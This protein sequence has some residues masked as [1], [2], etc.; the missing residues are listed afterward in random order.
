MMPM[1]FFFNE[2]KSLTLSAVKIF[3]VV[4]GRRRPVLTF[5]L[6]T[7]YGLSIILGQFNIMSI[8]RLG[9]NAVFLSFIDYEILTWGVRV[10]GSTC[11]KSG[12]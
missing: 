3:K 8:I 2:M 7:R 1:N 9:K 11:L 5:F 6:Q 12:A 10:E 4:S